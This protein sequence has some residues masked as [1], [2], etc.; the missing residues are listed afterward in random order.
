MNTPINFQKTVTTAGT[1]ETLIS[2]NEYGY[3][4]VK[5]LESNTSNIYVGD[6]DVTS[7]NGY[8]LES[9]ESIS[10][11]LDG[12]NKVYIDSDVNGEGVSAFGVVQ[13]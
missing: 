3:V 13:K 7:A 1:A 6:S 5:A 11:A 10:I 12:I 2:T 4:I 8:I 9:G